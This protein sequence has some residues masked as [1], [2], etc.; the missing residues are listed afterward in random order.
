VVARY[1]PK[2]VP[3]LETVSRQFLVF[4]KVINRHPQIVWRFQHG[5]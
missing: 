2:G 1:S 3:I 5:Q 4:S